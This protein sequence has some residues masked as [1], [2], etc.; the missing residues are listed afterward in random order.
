MK[1]MLNL[2][3]IK[4][5]E[6]KKDNINKVFASLGMVF[7]IVLGCLYAYSA[8]SILIGAEYDLLVALKIIFAG[9]DNP[10]II[11][12]Q[13]YVVLT[14]ELLGIITAIVLNVLY[15][16]SGKCRK[17]VAYSKTVL[18]FNLILGHMI[19]SS[20]K[21]TLMEN[22]IYS[23][24]IAVNLLL[25]L[26]FILIEVV[27][28]LSVYRYTR[29]ENNFAFVANEDK[30]V[31]DYLLISTLGLA[32]LSYFLLCIDYINSS[33][34]IFEQSFDYIWHNIIVPFINVFLACVI[35][36]TSLS[37]NKKTSMVLLTA[38][39]TLGI[40]NAVTAGYTINGLVQFGI[41]ATTADIGILFIILIFV[42][43]FLRSQEK[44]Y[45][46]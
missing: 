8:I 1:E 32:Y 39:A 25:S 35:W 38:I 31:W 44:Y 10:N 2:L 13:F 5:T 6:E 22:V 29:S 23:D 34:E 19:F 21:A 46:K 33:G 30:T 14:I 42:F 28:L 40:A 43:T 27:A 17:S 24:N 16:L 18:V 45:D 36:F 20:L 12:K 4:T 3:K 37:C 15:L 7:L 26:V 9:E 41:E 11:S